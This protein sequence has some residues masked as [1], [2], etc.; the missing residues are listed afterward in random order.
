MASM[1]MIL[2][3]LLKLPKGYPKDGRWELNRF[4]LGI[5]TNQMGIP[6]FL[7]S[8][9]G[10]T[11]D[12]KSIVKMIGEIQRNLKFEDKVYYLAD[13]ALYSAANIGEIS[14]H[15]FWISCVT[16]TITEAQ[17]L[18]MS[19]VSM[20]HHACTDERYAYYAPES[21]YGGI[22]QQWVMYQSFERLQSSQKKKGNNTEK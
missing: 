7:K 11:Q 4:V 18:R 6:V 5:A 22:S 12:K 14:E 10:N 1:T 21:N 13:S 20:T 3:I 19:P 15:S 2:P 16:H 17:T 9:S 8:F